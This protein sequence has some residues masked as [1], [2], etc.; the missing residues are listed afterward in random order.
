MSNYLLWLTH[1]TPVLHPGRR[2]ASVG[3]FPT[4][5]FSSPFPNC[6]SSVPSFVNCHSH[7]ISAVLSLGKSSPVGTLCLIPLLSEP[8]FVLLFTGFHLIQFRLFLQFFLIILNSHP[9][10]PGA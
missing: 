9:V 2:F 4:A 1:S 8:Q 10:L 7:S 5:H 3:V 6:T